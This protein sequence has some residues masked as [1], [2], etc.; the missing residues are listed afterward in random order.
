MIVIKKDGLKL[1]IGSEYSCLEIENGAGL[2]LPH[3]F[4]DSCYT[5]SGRTAIETVLLNEPNIK[6]ILVP[7]YCCNSMLEPIKKHNIELCF[8]YVGFQDELKIKLEIT[9]DIDAILWCNYFGF[10]NLMPDLSAFIKCGGIVIEDITHSLFSESSYHIQSTYLVAS[11][12]K[13]IPILCGGYIASKKKSLK[14][15]PK[16]YPSS[17]FLNL[18]IQA[19]LIKEKYLHDDI[20][21]DKNIFLKMF[22]ESND[23]LSKNYSGI[24]IDTRSENIINTI[25]Q[26]KIVDQRR[27][28]AMVLYN[29][30]KETNNISFLF[31][32]SAMDCPLFVPIKVNNEY[33][34]I[35]RKRLVKNNIFCPIH[36]PKPFAECESNL[37]DIEISLVCDQRYSEIDMM[38]IVR[39]INEESGRND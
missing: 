10:K 29:G 8:F 1:E 6:K 17:E 23:L 22:E 31:K 34:D 15:K 38:K 39:I 32:K 28:N 5:F 36:W 3:D 33:R 21:I 13:W 24:T 35:L 2:N 27:N 19:M 7:S 30:I 16:I 12:R 9:D 11:I 18:K 26:E 14:V 25:N 20:S 4:A 37:Y